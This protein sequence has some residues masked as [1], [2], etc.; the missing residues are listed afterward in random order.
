MSGVGFLFIGSPI[1]VDRDDLIIRPYTGA[2]QIN[3]SDGLSKYG[4]TL[5]VNVDNV[6]IGIDDGNNLQISPSF[7]SSI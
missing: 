5:A 2:S 6:S 1:V 7:I 4:N 3:V